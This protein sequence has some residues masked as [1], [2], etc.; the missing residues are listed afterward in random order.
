MFHP[1]NGRDLFLIFFFIVYCKTL[2]IVLCYLHSHRL[3]C[4]SKILVDHFSG[5]EFHHATKEII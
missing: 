3:I 1:I 4:M 5:R 2:I